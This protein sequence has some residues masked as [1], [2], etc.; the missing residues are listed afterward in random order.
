V[1]VGHEVCV[2]AGCVGATQICV[3]LAT[4]TSSCCY[5]KHGG[6]GEPDLH[7]DKQAELMVV[8]MHRERVMPSWQC[9]ASTHACTSAPCADHGPMGPVTL[10][11]MVTHTSAACPLAP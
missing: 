8:I 7:C 9:H 10:N 5:G 11:G 6:L 4:L 3:L 1:C 2:G